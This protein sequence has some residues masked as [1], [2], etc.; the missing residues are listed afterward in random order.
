MLW[1][2][3]KCRNI[4]GSKHLGVT[5]TNKGKPIILSKCTGRDIKSQDL[6]KNNKL[7]YC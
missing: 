6:S 3:L 5:K 7:V 1:Y 2:C 4:T